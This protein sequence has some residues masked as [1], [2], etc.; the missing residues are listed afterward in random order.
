MFYKV[1]K[2]IQNNKYYIPLVS[3]CASLLI[4]F[5]VSVLIMYNR[6]ESLSVRYD[7]SLK[8]FNEANDK[9]LSENMAAFEKTIFGSFTEQQ[10][11]KIGQKNSNYGISI[12]GDPLGLSESVVYSDRPTVAVL[13]S[14][15][16]GKDSLNYLPR[17]V[18]EKGSIIDLKNAESLI[19]VTHGDAKLEN[20]VYDY[21]YGKTLSYLVSDLKPGDIVTIEVNPDIARKIGME[22]NIVEIFYNKE[23]IEVS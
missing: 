16:Y 21:F 5:S 2:F 12:N 20:N 15:N 17:S 7:E 6:T 4:V 9:M 22:D 18:I 1:G 19:K 13:L 8:A 11:I 14:E 23:T 10:I 3:V